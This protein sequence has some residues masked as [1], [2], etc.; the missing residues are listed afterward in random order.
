[1]ANTGFG[2]R[3]DSNRCGV[4]GFGVI[5]CRSIAHRTVRLIP[6]RGSAKAQG[7]ESVNQEPDDDAARYGVVCRARRRDGLAAPSILMS[8]RTLNGSHAL[9][10]DA[11]RLRAIDAMRLR[12]S[13]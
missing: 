4:A 8:Q 6:N 12:A 11:M 10:I 9:D 3:P 2:G 7:I 5:P 13:A 1:V